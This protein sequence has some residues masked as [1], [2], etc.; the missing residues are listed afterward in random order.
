MKEEHQGCNRKHIAVSHDQSIVCC[1]TPD[2]MVWNTHPRV[3]LD[4]AAHGHVTCPYCG[5]QFRYEYDG[6]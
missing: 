2:Q 4:I 5:T 1:P 3:Y 6:V